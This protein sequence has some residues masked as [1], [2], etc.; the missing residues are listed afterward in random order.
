MCVVSMIMDNEYDKWK[1]RWPW[2]P[3]EQPYV[4]IEPSYPTVFPPYNP[5]INPI[6]PTQEELEEFRELLKRA[7]EYDKKNNE[8]DCELETKKQKLLDL[9]KQ[10]GIYKKVKAI[11][12][13]K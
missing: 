1:K 8:P 11:L 12:N 7:R 9:A 4:P 13:E 3:T 5:V 2:C 6:G 10:L